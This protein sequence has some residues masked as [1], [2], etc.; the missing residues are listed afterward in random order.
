MPSIKRILIVLDVYN[1]FRD[2]RTHLPIEI[3]KALQLIGDP[4]DTTLYLIGCGFEEY[5][6]D[7][8]ADSDTASTEQRRKFTD[9]L[10]E[11]L[12]TCGAALTKQGFSVDCRVH[13]TYPRY[14]QIAQ[15]AEI[16]NAD[17]VVQHVNVRQ[18]H[19]RHNLSHDTWQLVK[20]CKRSIL[21]V[22]D[23]EWRRD[24]IILAAVDPMHSFHKPAGL[25]QTIVQAALDI[26]TR[27]SG[28]VHLV[29]A[30]TESA[31]ALAVTGAIRELHCKAMDQMLSS[32]SLP[33]HAIHLVDDTPSNAILQC[34]DAL[35]ADL[36]VMGAL[37][38]S[39][40]IEAIIGNTAERVLDYAK[41]DLYIIRPG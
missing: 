16:L 6:H 10:T 2:D 23:S 38:R 18:A 14:E 13:W 31:R 15:E 27:I 34:R 1:D 25:D 17:L 36:I 40:L 41:S 9:E 5:L 8:Y 12:N 22:K 19:A 35:K 7:T 29:H 4:A 21:L 30:Y 33:A 32:F 11:R 26:S 37:S 20:N 3:R 28:A 24:P 39:R